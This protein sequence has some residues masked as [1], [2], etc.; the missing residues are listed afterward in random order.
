MIINAGIKLGKV[1]QKNIF[2]ILL[3]IAAA[4]LSALTS[5]NVIFILIGAM[6]IGIIYS[7]FSQKKKSAEETK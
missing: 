5:V 1:N 4:L 2:N 3:T 6:M 7:L